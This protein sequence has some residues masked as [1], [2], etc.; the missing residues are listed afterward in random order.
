MNGNQLV[1]ERLTWLW[2]RIH[3]S[4]PNS[5]QGTASPAW[6]IF[7]GRSK[8]RIWPAYGSQRMSGS[9]SAPPDE[10]GRNWLPRFA[11]LWGRRPSPQVTYCQHVITHYSTPFTNAD[12]R[13]T[14]IVAPVLV[15]NST[16]VIQHL[17]QPAPPGNFRGC[18]GLSISGTK[19]RDLVTTHF[20]V[21]YHTPRADIK[22]AG[23]FQASGYIE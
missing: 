21:L 1:T 17:H 14:A 23:T 10:S 13:S 16:V 9:R 5:L 6:R 4:V 12:L 20:L 7:S 3:R 15:F 22:E 19:H 11:L 2:A 8:S 18:H